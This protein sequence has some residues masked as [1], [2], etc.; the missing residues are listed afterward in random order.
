[1]KVE[2]KSEFPVTNEA[3]FAATGK[4]LDE[5]FKLPELQTMTRRDAIH[6]LY[7]MNGRGKD[8]WWSTTIWVEYERFKGLVKKDGLYEGYNIC[9]TKSVKASAEDVYEAWTDASKCGWFGGSAS[10]VEGATFFDDGGNEGTWL[11]LRPGKDVRIAWKT[12]GKENPTQVD[13]AFVEKDG[14]T[15]ITVQHSRIQDREEADGI[16][17]AWSDALAKLKLQL[18]D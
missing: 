10:A 13:A 9:S 18:E 3:C 2:L 5:W 14:K 17:A 15:M 1:M 11:R 12:K 16:R 4:S 6:L 8:V 7:D